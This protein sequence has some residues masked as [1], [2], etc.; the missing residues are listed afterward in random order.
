MNWEGV[1]EWL[2]KRENADIVNNIDQ[3]VLFGE[4]GLSNEL[5]IKYSNFYGPPLEDQFLWTLK[6][7]VE[8][9]GMQFFSKADQPIVKAMDQIPFVYIRSNRKGAPS[10]EVFEAQARILTESLSEKL[11]LKTQSSGLEYSHLQSA[12]RTMRS[13]RSPRHLQSGGDFV[14]EFQDSLQ[15]HLSSFEILEPKLKKT[16][17]YP[18]TK[19]TINVTDKT[20]AFKDLYVLVGSFVWLF[21]VYL[22][23]NVSLFLRLFMLLF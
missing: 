15:E 21:L 11:G 23:F 10:L 9:S 18:S 12:L 13:P 5:S 17:L 3:I 19:L 7:K 4:L 14:R 22:L 20:S 16:S 8:D 1:Q 6:K 2:T